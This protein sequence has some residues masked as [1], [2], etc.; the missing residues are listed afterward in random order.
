DYFDDVLLGFGWSWDDEPYWYS[1]EVS[2]LSFNDN[3]VDFSIAAQQP[4]MP[5]VVTWEPAGT[6]YVRVRNQTVTAAAG[7]DLEE[8]YARTRD[9]NDFTLSSEVPEG[10][11]DLESLSVHNP[12]AYFVHVLR[13][14]LLREG[15]AVGGRAVDVDDLS[16]KPDYARLTP[17]A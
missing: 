16:I 3:T 7:A 8:G 11:T 5:G 17:L 4:G 6:D 1:A 12:T 15:I 2:A 13:E 10:R 14:T 9:G